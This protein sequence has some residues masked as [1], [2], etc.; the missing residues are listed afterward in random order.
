MYRAPCRRVA[1]PCITL[2]LRHADCQ[3]KHVHVYRSSYKYVCVC[4]LIQGLQPIMLADIR[5]VCR[6]MDTCWDDKKIPNIDIL[7]L[8]HKMDKMP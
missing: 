8:L 1:V 5:N 4:V 7:T 2:P 3:C 6:Y